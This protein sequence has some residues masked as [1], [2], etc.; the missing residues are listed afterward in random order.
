MREGKERREPSHSYPRRYSSVT[1][2]IFTDK[3]TQLFKRRDLVEI[4]L[5]KFR[6]LK[7][8]G[9][10]REYIEEFNKCLL[11]IDFEFSENL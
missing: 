3:M 10:L 8:S 5:S 1:L 4:N 11:S 7:Q 9:D 2:D 6:T